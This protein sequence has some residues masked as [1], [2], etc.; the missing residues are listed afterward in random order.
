[1]HKPS[2]HKNQSLTSRALGGATWF[3]A[4]SVFSKGL[5]T[6]AQ[7]VLAW[8]LLPE[9][10]GVVSIAMT[11][12]GIVA[13]L[14]EPGFRTI[15][16]R[17]TWR[18]RGLKRTVHFMSI[19]TGAVASLVTL[20]CA[21]VI[22]YLYELPSLLPLL[23]I[24]AICPLIRSMTIVQLAHLEGKM[25]FRTLA[26]LQ[27]METV[28][29]AGLSIVLAVAGFGP[30]SIILPMPMTLIAR[31]VVLTRTMHLRLFPIRVHADHAKRIARE[32]APLFATAIVG[33]LFGYGDFI[34]ISMTCSTEELGLYFFAFGLG[35]Q[36]LVVFA[37]GLRNVLF[38][39]LSSIQ[40]ERGRQEGAFA[41][42][43]HVLSAIVAPLMLLQAAV[44]APVFDVLFASRWDGAILIFQL[45]CFGFL[46]QAIGYPVGSLL[47]SQGRFSA[48]FSIHVVASLCYVTFCAAGALLYGVVG[49]TIGATAAFIVLIPIFLCVAVGARRGAA[50]VFRVLS[51]PV[52]LATLAFIASVTLSQQLEANSASSIVVALC[53]GAVFL[54]IYLAGWTLMDRDQVILTLG[55]I[56]KKLGFARRQ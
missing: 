38:S 47:R 25:H 7:I 19:S 14:E 41:R 49:A 51:G 20:G 42:S 45:L 2:A 33:I 3:A 24:L 55:M 36:F 12:F 53:G 21:P 18:F 30:F 23:I 13:V 26:G 48:Y 8:H 44:A 29:R 10:Y 35:K 39:A 43:V 27:A 6:L 54:T 9:D 1:M 22:S 31:Y 16:V 46:G 37:I 52:A 32:C 40:N 50:I 28:I 4:Q 11:V 56:R 5:G 34:I 15:L 17:E